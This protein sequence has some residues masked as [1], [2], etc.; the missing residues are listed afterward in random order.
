MKCGAYTVPG[1]CPQ[2]L[3]LLPVPELMPPSSLW[4]LTLAQG[5]Q[6]MLGTSHK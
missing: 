6:G 5:C 2:H 3:P 1:I 4:I